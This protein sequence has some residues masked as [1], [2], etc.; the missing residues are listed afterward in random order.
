[1]PPTN[2]RRSGA[3]AH[4]PR[5]IRRRGVWYNETPHT[6]RPRPRAARHSSTPTERVLSRRQFWSWSVSPWTKT[7]DACLPGAWPALTKRIGLYNEKRVWWAVE[8][9]GESTR[10]EE[11]DMGL[12]YLPLPLS[13]RWN[14]EGRQP[15]GSGHRPLAAWTRPWNRPGC[16]VGVVGRELCAAPS[17]S[18]GQADTGR[19]SAAWPKSEGGRRAQVYEKSP[20]AP[21]VRAAQ[22]TAVR[23]GHLHR[24]GSW[25]DTTRTSAR[26]K[27]PSQGRSA[28]G[29]APGR[30][31]EG[32]KPSFSGPQHRGIALRWALSPTSS[33]CVDRLSAG[34]TKSAC[35][36]PQLAQAA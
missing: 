12:E 7:G 28:V 22:P 10:G 19:L 9:E 8:G 15:G 13:C 36:P 34:C 29:W 14:G 4:R 18:P 33:P 23:P 30:R 24:A 35:R 20:A 26:G 3:G 6:A 21:S 1:M 11:G 25:Y 27:W 5:S 31:G 16:T 2:W 17:A 32:V